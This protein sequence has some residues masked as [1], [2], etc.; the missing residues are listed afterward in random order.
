MDLPANRTIRTTT[1]NGTY[2]YSIAAN[3]PGRYQLLGYTAYQYNLSTI[4]YIHTKHI[5][6]PLQYMHPFYR[7]LLTKQTHLNH[8]TLP[9][10]HYTHLTPSTNLHLVAPRTIKPAPIDWGNLFPTQPKN[11]NIGEYTNLLTAHH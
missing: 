6:N 4:F 3:D 5:Q 9:M 1:Q 10:L 11:T 7:K 8:L 2:L